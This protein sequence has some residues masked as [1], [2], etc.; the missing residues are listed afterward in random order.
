MR[1]S[2]SLGQNGRLS[3]GVHLSSWADGSQ[4][5]GWQN[6]PCVRKQTGGADHLGRATYD[7]T[8]R[9][10]VLVTLVGPPFRSQSQLGATGLT[11]LKL[12]AV[13]LELRRCEV[14]GPFWI[15]VR[16]VE[17]G[18]GGMCRLLRGERVSLS[19]GLEA[20]WG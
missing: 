7:K 14:P 10:R 6:F 12:V 18:Q 20:T 3:T 11:G 9:F 2:V 8:T 4:Y 5:I 16:R 15:T 17:G 19:G 1:L 13:L